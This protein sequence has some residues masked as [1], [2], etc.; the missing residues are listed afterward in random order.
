MTQQKVIPGSIL[1]FYQPVKST[2]KNKHSSNASS[3]TTTT[4]ISNN[5]SIPPIPSISQTEKSFHITKGKSP[6][7]TEKAKQS[8]SNL[9]QQQSLPKQPSIIAPIPSSSSSSSSLLSNRQQQQQLQKQRQKTQKEKTVYEPESTIHIPATSCLSWIQRHTTLLVTA[10]TNPAYA[11]DFFQI[12]AN[13]AIAGFDLDSTIVRT[14]SRTPFPADGDDWQWLMPS[15]RDTLVLFTSLLSP[16]QQYQQ[17][18][19]EM[20]NNAL[21]TPLVAE[22]LESIYSRKSSSSS[23]GSEFVPYILVI[24]SNQGGVIIK[25]G[26]KRY[27]NYKERLNQIAEN[28]QIPF[29]SYAATKASMK[30]LPKQAQ[31]KGNPAAAATNP[32]QIDIFR[33]PEIGMWEELLKELGHYGCQVDLQKSFFVGDAA[34][35]KNDF[36]NS[37][38]MF[39]Q[40]IGLKFFTPQQFFLPT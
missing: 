35:R 38:K 33:K 14:K 16:E 17:L 24:F 9:Q 39:A 21:V 30:K 27:C 8:K 11:F 15:V 3:T 23:S 20:N 25:D 2:I 13:V 31:K 5:T 4:T 32:P 28:A 6:R 10:T 12:P 40:G 29:L 22:F 37:D 19:L 18:V 36:S 1:R 26:T 7:Q 34:G